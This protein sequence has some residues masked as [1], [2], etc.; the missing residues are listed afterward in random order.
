MSPPASVLLYHSE[1]KTPGVTFVSG[2]RFI[3]K[4][5][6]LLFWFQVSTD[7]SDAVF[8]K[9]YGQTANNKM[10]QGPRFPHTSMRDS[11][12]AI[13]Q[14]LPRAESLKRG[15]QN[16]V[17]YKLTSKQ[18]PIQVTNTGIILHRTNCERD[19]TGLL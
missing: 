8:E 19:I 14:M 5:R 12:N 6:M 1:H 9:L 10:L 11:S 4:T 3:T 15:P 17:Q 18:N 7:R 2:Q 13:R 16:K